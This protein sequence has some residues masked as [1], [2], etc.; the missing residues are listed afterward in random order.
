MHI[1]T[2][3]T[4]DVS[5]SKS[6]EVCIAVPRRKKLGRE[7]LCS[8]CERLPRQAVATSTRPGGGRG[9]PSPQRLKLGA[10][11]A[12]PR[13]GGRTASPAPQRTGTGP[14]RPCRGPGTEPSGPSEAGL[15]AIGGRCQQRMLPLDVGSQPAGASTP[16]SIEQAAAEEQRRGGEAASAALP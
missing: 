5:G 6:V 11:A 12:A 16:S 7:G 1:R 13:R 9:T 10:S 2:Y 3:K 4:A 15:G 8:L 14:C